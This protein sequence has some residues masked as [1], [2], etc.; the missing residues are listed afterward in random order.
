MDAALA[1]IDQNANEQPS[2]TDDGMDPELAA[3]LAQ[4]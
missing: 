3:L 2:L 4:L 1:S